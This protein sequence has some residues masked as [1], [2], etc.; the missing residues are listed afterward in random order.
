M[1]IGVVGWGSVR[2]WEG[3]DWRGRG[4]SPIKDSIDR[5]LVRESLGAGVAV[6]GGVVNGIPSAVDLWD[7][8]FVVSFI[9]SP[10]LLSALSAPLAF[11]PCQT[12]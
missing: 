8:L 4:T 2:G 12:D 10:E 7:S 11:Y 5:F 9:D 3:G 6:C 1:V